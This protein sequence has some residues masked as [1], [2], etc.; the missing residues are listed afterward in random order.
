MKYGLGTVEWRNWTGIERTGLEPSGLEWTG[1]DWSI[2]KWNEYDKSGLQCRGIDWGRL[3]WTLSVLDWS[4]Q[5]RIGWGLT[6]VE[7]NGLEQT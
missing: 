5:D 1:L 2:F 4:R 6:R 3:H 7:G